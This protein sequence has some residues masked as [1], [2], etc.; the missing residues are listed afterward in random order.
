MKKSEL[1]HGYKVRFYG[2]ENW[3]ENRYGGK[4]YTYTFL[5]PLKVFRPTNELNMIKYEI[6]L[7]SFDEKLEPIHD[8]PYKIVQ[9]FDKNENLIFEDKELIK[10]EKISFE[11][12]KKW[13]NEHKDDE[14]IECMGG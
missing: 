14:W 1:K 11:N 6:K 2:F 7:S 13:I 3:A 9:I 8:S 10:K 12:H 5:S 4:P